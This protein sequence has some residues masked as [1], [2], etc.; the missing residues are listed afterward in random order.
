MVTGHV[1][2]G[3]TS[4]AV[5]RRQHYHVGG[6]ISGRVGENLGHGGKIFRKIF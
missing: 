2:S 4:A 3:I 1:G 5:S 6:E